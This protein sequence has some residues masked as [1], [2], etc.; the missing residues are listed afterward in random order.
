MQSV[1]SIAGSDP[2]GGA[3]LQADLQVFRSLGVHGGAVPTALTIQDGLRVQQVLPVFPSVLLEQLRT[4][5]DALRP[6]AIK[7]GMLATDDGV[8]NVLLGLAMAEGTPV[9][10]DPV[11][12]ASDG[13][14]LLEKRAYGALR[15]LIFRRSLLTPNWPEMEIL[16]DASLDRRRDAEAAGRELVADLELS[17]ILLKGGHR[18]RD[19]DDLLVTRSGR[20]TE[21]AEIQCEWLPGERL[22][23]PPAHGTG[24]ALSAAIAAGLAKGQP[25]REAVTEAR[26]YVRTAI[27]NAFELHNGARIL[28]FQ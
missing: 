24:C 27:E 1:L 19:A 20:S 23:G 22:P 17:G 25:L 16:V 5:L 13:T 2:T 18:D 21:S 3:G 8:R 12:A 10:I 6:S 11:L 14:P 15:D 7:I 9:V 26:R 28:A 4:T